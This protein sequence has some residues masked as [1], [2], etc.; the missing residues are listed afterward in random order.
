LASA[1][2]IPEA[3]PVI[4][5]AVLKIKVHVLRILQGRQNL[6]YLPAT[7]QMSIPFHIFNFKFINRKTARYTRFRSKREPRSDRLYGGLWK[8]R[9]GGSEGVASIPASTKQTKQ[10]G[11]NP[12]LF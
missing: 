2:P 5:A 9:L 7:I 11:F 4:I 6:R 8:D 1:K 12:I 10:T 3:P